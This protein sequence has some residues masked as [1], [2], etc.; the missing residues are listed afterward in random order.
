MD[1]VLVGLRFRERANWFPCYSG[2]FP[3]AVCERD[4]MVVGWSC[5]RSAIGEDP[6]RPCSRDGECGEVPFEQG[7]KTKIRRQYPTGL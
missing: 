3:S 1:H 4:G 7:Y 5:S 2:W 6:A